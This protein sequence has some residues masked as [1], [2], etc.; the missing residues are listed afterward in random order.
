MPASTMRTL[1][2]VSA[3]GCL[4]ILAPF[5][6]AACCPTATALGVGTPQLLSGYAEPLR[7][8][9]P[10]SLDPDE[11]PAADALRAE[12]VPASD[13]SRHGVAEQ[14]LDVGGIY[15]VSHSSGS[16]TWIDIGS[17]RPMREAAAILLL[18]VR[19]GS[20]MIV[21]EVP[22]LF[23]PATPPA[24][25]VAAA[26]VPAT[27]QHAMPAAAASAPASLRARHPR[28]PV[29]PHPQRHVA[30]HPVPAAAPAYSSASTGLRLA[31]RFD[32]L[33]SWQPDHR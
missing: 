4:R 16:A 25:P 17:A 6:L 11:A 13:Y 2:G 26:P 10:V 19:L 23:E 27:D 24:E 9:V 21:R 32:S 12:L 33:A 15:A 1:C 14:P 31:E 8:R 29:R 3:P 18:R 7:V 28:A 22:L 5:L 30:V 20:T